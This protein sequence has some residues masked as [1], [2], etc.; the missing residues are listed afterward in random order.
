[1]RPRKIK[2]NPK[3]SPGLLFAVRCFL[4]IIWAIPRLPTKFFAPLNTGH[5]TA[6]TS[7]R[8][9]FAIFCIERNRHQAGGE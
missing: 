8:A 1:M 2:L 3:R 7:A 5:L 4:T 9:L 6:G